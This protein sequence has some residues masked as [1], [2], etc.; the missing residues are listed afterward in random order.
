MRAL[1]A[2]H[3]A[4]FGRA[5]CRATFRYSVRRSND[6]MHNASEDHSPLRVAIVAPSMGIL[7]GQAVQ[8]DRLLRAW[9]GDPDVHAWLVPDQPDPAGIAP[10]RASTSNT[11]ARSRRSCPTG[12]CSSASC[13]TPT[14]STCSRPRTSRSCSRPLPAVLVAKLLGKPVVM[15]YRSGQAPDHLQRSAHRARRRCGGSSGTPSRRASSRTS[16]R[17]HGIRAEVIPNIVDVDRFSFRHAAAARARTSCRRATSR[18]STTSPA[19]CARSGWC[20]TATRRRR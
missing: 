8:A 1:F 18:R 3:T 10:A 13:G 14:S 16:S 19:R 5:A 11:C 4:S 7:G 17:E 2:R 20:R 12:R 9:Q 15:N 6:L